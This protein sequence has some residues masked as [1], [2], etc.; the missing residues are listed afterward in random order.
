MSC[1]KAKVD[2]VVHTLAKDVGS[3]RYLPAT[4][5][6]TLLLPFESQVAL[7]PASACELTLW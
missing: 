7:A 4:S 2:R 5:M 3:R 1:I 6:P